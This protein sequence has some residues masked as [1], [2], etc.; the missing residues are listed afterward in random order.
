MVATE[1]VSHLS[2]GLHNLDL[3]SRPAREL[4]GRA[5][6][7]RI[8]REE[9][10]RTLGLL[11][12]LDIPEDGGVAIVL[13][14]YDV[15]ANGLGSACAPSGTKAAEA[16]LDIFAGTSRYMLLTGRRLITL[17][18]SAEPSIRFEKLGGASAQ[19]NRREWLNKD[20][21]L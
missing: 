3:R 4:A 18:Q 6:V 16:L 14:S 15:Y 17:V 1:G 5:V 2:R 8:L 13:Y 21:G 10:E 11:S 19:W 9:P 20:R 12:D 7:S